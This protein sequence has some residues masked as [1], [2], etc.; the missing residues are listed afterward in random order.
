V[1]N[2]KTN[3]TTAL[4][5]DDNEID[6]MVMSKILN[7]M[8][9]SSDCATG[10]KEASEMIKNKS[11]SFIICDIHMPEMDG[12]ETIELLMGQSKESKIPFVFYTSGEITDALL[13]I[14]FESGAFGVISKQQNI[15]VIK[16]M[17]NS[18]IELSKYRDN[19]NLLSE[20]KPA[21]DVKSISTVKLPQ[22]AENL[23]LESKIFSRI[24]ENAT[25]MFIDFVGYTEISKEM[26]LEMLIKK[27]H[28]Y[29][30]KFDEI[31][32]K[33]GLNKIKTIGDSYMCAG[34]VPVSNPINSHM[35]LLAAMEIDEYVSGLAEIDI[36]NGVKPWKVRIGVDVG[37]VIAGFLTKDPH[38]VDIWGDTVN[39]ASRIE[40]SANVGE[41]LVSESMKQRVKEA[42]LFEDKGS[43]NLKGTGE[44]NLFKLLSVNDKYKGVKKEDLKHLLYEHFYDNKK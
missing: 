26:K 15:S 44:H 39:L 24:Y 32:E 9:I 19:H 41:T 29:Y 1:L 3:T 22:K 20:K 25:V 27:L 36:K 43:F 6:K 4:F 17:L 31:M 11:Y 38:N 40:S 37:E 33:F 14:A 2:D 34:G 12:F 7:T 18:I 10:G 35:V 13:T 8:G 16:G 30:S 5:I 23:A 28:Q 42:F 21:K